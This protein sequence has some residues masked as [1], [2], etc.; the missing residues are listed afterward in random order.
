MKKVMLYL[1]VLVLAGLAYLALTLL[2]NAS[3]NDADVTTSVTGID[4]TNREVQEYLAQ[5]QRELRG[6]GETPSSLFSSGKVGSQQS[7]SV[8]PIQSEKTFIPVPQHHYKIIAK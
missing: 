4:Y 2:D 7:F 3:R 5:K 8:A 6:D 1:T